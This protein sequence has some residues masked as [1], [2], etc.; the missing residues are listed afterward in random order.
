MFFVVNI[1]WDPRTLAKAPSI[2]KFNKTSFFFPSLWYSINCIVL[3]F[4][5]SF[6]SVL[7]SFELFLFTPT[8]SKLC[9]HITKMMPTEAELRG[10]DRQVTTPLLNFLLFKKIKLDILHKRLPLILD[11]TEPIAQWLAVFE[12]EFLWLCL[13]RDI[14]PSIFFFFGFFHPNFFLS[15]AYHC[16][17]PTKA[18]SH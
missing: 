12:I 9:K 6:F 11:I 1:L 3:L 7:L 8:M 2:S 18:Q 15:V 4:S 5:F 17:F 10:K 16:R 13:N 14:L